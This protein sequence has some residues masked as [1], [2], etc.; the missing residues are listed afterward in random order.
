MLRTCIIIT[1]TYQPILYV[2]YPPIRRR[3]LFISFVLKLNL[4]LPSCSTAFVKSVTVAIDLPGRGHKPN[5]ILFFFHR[6]VKYVRRPVENSAT[7]GRNNNNNKTVLFNYRD[8][9]RWRKQLQVTAV[10]GTPGHILPKLN[11]K[12]CPR[13]FSI[14][15]TCSPV[16]N[17]AGPFVP[18]GDVQSKIVTNL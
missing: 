8:N 4:R 11:V 2:V 7:K 12:Y 13:F 16:L 5:A 17:S 14:N 15:N 9:R 18:Y 6:C 3:L 10:R 1:M